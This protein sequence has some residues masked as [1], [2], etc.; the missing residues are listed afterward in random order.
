MDIFYKVKEK[1][2]LG[3]QLQNAYINDV[4]T[5]QSETNQAI[6]KMGEAMEKIAATQQKILE[7]K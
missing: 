4:L 1:V 5:H 7:S 6:L 3:D 2:K